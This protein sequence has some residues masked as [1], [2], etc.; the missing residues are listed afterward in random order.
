MKKLTVSSYILLFC[1]M[2]SAVAA[3]PVLQVSATL[4]TRVS[5]CRIVPVTLKVTN[6]GKSQVS[7]LDHPSE[8]A[9]TITVRDTGTGAVVYDG[10]IFI[11]RLSVEQIEPPPIKLAPGAVHAYSAMLRSRWVEEHAVG[12]FFERPGKF[13]VQFRIPLVFGEMQNSSFLHAH[14]E[15]VDILVADSPAKEARELATI[16][17]MPNR[18]WLFEPQEMPT[19]NSMVVLR[20]WEADLATFARRNPKSYWTP[21]AHIALA[22]VYLNWAYEKKASART[23]A[24][25]MAKVNRSVAKALGST[26]P[27]LVGAA[28][29]L[30]LSRERDDFQPKP[31]TP[32]APPPRPNHWDAAYTE[33]HAEFYDTRRASVGRAPWV[34]EMLRKETEL[35][36][37]GMLGQMP[38]EEAQRQAGEVAKE[39]IRKH[40]KPLSKSEWNRRYKIY[41]EQEKARQAR[42]R[43]EQMR[44]AP[45]NARI[46]RE[47]IEKRR[48]EQAKP[49]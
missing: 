40:E 6:T 32:V 22:H 43:A 45:E 21:H 28:R 20:N 9:T 18:A 4:P 12:G 30:L 46:L 41:A 26:A 49:K 24:K 34:K 17:N 37:K 14:T 42:Q 11:S 38:L 25:W 8:G 16:M 29:E 10:P 47:A 5:A 19:R 2:F 35:I 36:E 31:Q 1:A 3:E 44:D 27:I 48:R 39:Y 23:K 13:Q 7:I 33:L 15:W